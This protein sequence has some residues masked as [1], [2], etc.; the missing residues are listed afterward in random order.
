MPRINLAAVKPVLRVFCLILLVLI[1]PSTAIAQ[2][3]KGR[4]IDEQRPDVPLVGASVQVPNGK[5]GTMTDSS[6]RFSILPAQAVSFI[7][8]SFL[9]YQTQTV[10]IQDDNPDLT[11]RL[12]P[13]DARQLAEVRVQSKYY[14]QYATNTIS[15]ALRLQTALIDLPQNIQTV[16]PEIIY[17]QGSF[18]MTEGV[19]RNVSGVVRQ[20]VSNNL[21]PYMFMRGG[22]IATLRNGIDLTPIYRGPSPEDAAII[23]RV[24][25]VKGPSL[26]MNNI[27]DPAGSFNVVTKQPTG[28]RRYS[29]T[30]MLGS[31]N[32]Y[33]LAVDLDGQLDKK[34][35][36]LYRLNGMGMHTNSFVKFDNN[37]RFLI[38][39]VLKYRISDRT[40][41]SVEYQ[42]QSNRYAMYSPIVMTP[43]VDSPIG[44]STLPIDFSIHEPSLTPIRS[45]D[46]TG[47]LTVGHQFSANWQLTVR[48]AFMRNDNEGAYMWVTGVNTANPTVLLRNPKYDLNRT[49]VFSEQA[50]VNSKFT[51][52]R[53]KH[54]LLAGVDV[55]QKRFRADSYVQYDTYTDAQGKTQLRYY[56]LDIN[57]P[58]YG[59]EISNY[60]TPGGLINRNTTQTVN[61]RS[62]YALDELALF[63]NKLRLTLG[64]RYTSV[65]T[66][67]D[68]SGVTTTSSDNVATPR[69]GISYSLRPDLSVYALYD[70]TL[71]PQAGV[72]IG[73]EA[74]RPLEGTNREI[75]I[76]KN[77]FNG[78][79]NTTV[80]FYRIN[81]SNA[82]AT[83]PNNSLYRIQVGANHAQG[84]DF[85][86]VGQ[87]ARGLNAVVNYAYND[88]KIDN[89]VNMAL[90]GTPT[91][92]YVKHI[93]NTW[94]NYELPGT[95]VSGLTLSLGY[96][97]QGGRGERYATAT[98]HAIPNFFRLDGGI[99]WQYG[100]GQR[101]SFK[102]N[103]LVNN[104][105]NKTLIATAWYRSG[106][107]YWV[108]QA[109][110][111]GRLSV[112]YTF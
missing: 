46:H 91:P 52:G 37:Q 7:R 50:F 65:Q 27:G 106:L 17:D 35:K 96:Q 33:R 25:F 75:G 49:E 102:V 103:L 99:G 109:P 3:I 53:L 2:L 85:D 48:G 95:V 64:L 47:F 67:N 10:S 57:N 94:L 77:W 43:G 84:V 21:G 18:N 14:R 112:S 72:T 39:P 105:L 28:I 98:Q 31:F 107:Y 97:Y 66:R 81:R 68:V 78:R 76:K 69:L 55:N 60:H 5:Q 34:G 90:V 79:W 58:V 92:M 11:I 87:V 54:Q 61:Y 29:A 71:V 86:V 6:G 8:I 111:N 108:P 40:Y 56:P 62:F 51:T 59:A 45:H 36:L 9:G 26:F 19:S 83:D 32:F 23:D 22:Q 80:A 4:V 73:G 82:I 20:E 93:Q 30:A 100:S 15:S 13:D 70:R 88:S 44:F 104:L 1:S 89:D 63:A 110:V 101:N 41:V 42:Y 74:I 24:E 38:A 12:V 16:T